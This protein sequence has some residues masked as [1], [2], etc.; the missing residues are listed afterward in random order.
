MR[1]GCHVKLP[2]KIV[3]KRAVVNVQSADNACFAWSVVAALYPAERHVER[4]FYPHYTTVLNLQNIEF[5]VTVNHIKKFELANDI[6]VNVY[7]IEN[8]NIVPLRLSKQ[9][10]DKHVN[11]LYVKDEN[12]VGYF[13]L[14]KNLSRL[15]SSQ[16]NKQKCRRY[17]CDRCLHYFFSKDKLQAHTVD[18]GK[19][20]DCA[21]RLPSDKD[22][23][24]SF[25][26]YTRK[27]RLPFVVYADLECVLTKI[28]DSFKFALCRLKHLILCEF[29]KTSAPIVKEICGAADS[30]GIEP[31]ARQLATQIMDYTLDDSQTSDDECKIVAEMTKKPKIEVITIEDNN[32]SWQYRYRCPNYL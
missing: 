22:K 3:T 28:E 2:R 18:C 12:S 8:E 13:A 11:L 15:V 17:I 6:S 30:R 23:W 16:L 14:I 32:V 4:E 31:L 20:N 1:A 9:K 7:S 21:I 24:L 19:L 27:E 25:D 10:R 5:P 29:L 26:N